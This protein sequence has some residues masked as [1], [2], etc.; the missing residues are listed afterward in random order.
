MYKADFIPWQH[1]ACLWSNIS[2]IE[3]KYRS[4]SD[5]FSMPNVELAIFK[6]SPLAYYDHLPYINK[7]KSNTE[8]QP[9]QT[10]PILRK[11]LW[12]KAP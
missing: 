11:I 1:H 9:A 4:I 10:N 2:R 8:I 7:D 12:T 3:A 5:L 6:P